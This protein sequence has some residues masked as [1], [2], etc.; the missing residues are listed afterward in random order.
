MEYINQVEQVELKHQFPNLCFFFSKLKL[1]L[2]EGG[3]R[4]LFFR[5]R[6][7]EIFRDA[8]VWRSEYESYGPEVWEKEVAAAE[9]RCG[10]MIRN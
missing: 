3:L 7:P 4:A 2:E 5:S 9:V 8:G 6:H 10:K 1:V